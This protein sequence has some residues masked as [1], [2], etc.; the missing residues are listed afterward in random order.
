[1]AVP[2]FRRLCLCVCVKTAFRETQW[3]TGNTTVRFQYGRTTSYGSTTANQTKTGNAFQSVTANISG[4]TARTTCH[5]RIVPPTAPALGTAA[6]GLLPPNDAANV[7][8]TKEH[9]GEFK[10]Q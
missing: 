10:E 7:I 2:Q 8:E 3:A 1:M 9:T 6:T 4:L 5:F